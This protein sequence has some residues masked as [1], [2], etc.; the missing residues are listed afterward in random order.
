[1]ATHAQIERLAR[2]LRQTLALDHIRLGNEYRYAHLTLVL[3]D[4]IFSPGIRYS[5]TEQIVERYAAHQRLTR[6]RPAFDQWPPEGTQEPIEALARLGAEMQDDHLTDRVFGSRH[7]TSTRNGVLKARAVTDAA[8]LFHGARVDRFQDLGRIVDDAAF[9]QAYHALPGQASGVSW[10]YF[11]M[12]AG[13][14]N[15]I[16]PDRHVLAYLARALGQ[17]PMSAREALDLVVGAAELLGRDGYAVTP[18]ELD[19]A[20]WEYQRTHT[21]RG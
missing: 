1:M 20:M 6:Y 14:Q 13:D 9:A 8:A 21:R 3:V 11:W 7:R 10:A 19:Y 15:L 12:L 2:Y 16:K 17:P 4:A 5:V 18:R